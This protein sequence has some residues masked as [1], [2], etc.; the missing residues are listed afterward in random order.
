M[1]SIRKHAK[2]WRV[3]VARKGVRRSK[4]FP[5]RRAAQDWG[6]R[7]EYLILE[8]GQGLRDSRTTLGDMLDR[9]AREVSPAK[10]GHRWEVLRLERM[11]ADKIGAIRL[12]D[13]KASDLA[14]WRDRRLRDVAPG[15]VRRE[16]TLLSHAFNVARREW[17]LIQVNPLRDISRP[18]EP[19][20]RDRLPAQEEIERLAHVAGD[21]LTL[22]TARAF[23]AFLFAGETAMRAGEICGLTWGLVDLERRVARLPRTKNG[24]AREVPLSSE[25][26]RMLA[27]LPR[28]DPVFGLRSD[29]LDALWRKVR[30]KARV[31]GLTFHDS[32]AWA[33]TKLSR[34]VDVMTLARITG[35]RDL[36]ILMNTYYRE[37]AGDV[38]KRLD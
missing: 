37:T 31:E 17:G 38:A 35:H 15:S 12:C 19:P 32:R 20:P 7:Q 25:A 27:A 6:A 13:L 30:A 5:T 4:V 16:M 24:S 23:H 21:D 8:E 3:E 34:K 11:R 29:Q 26:V 9:Y 33:A 1:A 2:G 22:A 28:M 10:R 18:S 36:R 14:D